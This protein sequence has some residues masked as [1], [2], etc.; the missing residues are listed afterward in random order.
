MDL[1]QYKGQAFTIPNI[2]SYIRFAM[3]PAFVVVFL[4]A[5]ENPR[6]YITALSILI[7][8]GLTDFFDG[9]IARKFNQITPLGKLLDPL[10]DK[11]TCIAVTICLCFKIPFV[12]PLTILY[13]LKEGTMIA[14]GIILLKH[15]K[16]V[17]ASKWYGKLATFVF[18]FSMLALVAM[19]LDKTLI[20]WIY[21]I[22]ILNM[23]LITFAFLKYVSLFW[24]IWNA[25]KAEQQA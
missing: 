7:A 19:P 20:P 3:I 12:M 14:A 1:K 22:V 24:Q 25:P 15:H 18:Y 11:F 21:G 5:K 16:P 4:L 23:L 2:L 10:A 17:S 6:L 9:K 8:S 13:C